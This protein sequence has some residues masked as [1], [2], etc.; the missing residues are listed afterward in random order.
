MLIVKIATWILRGLNQRFPKCRAK[1]DRFE[2]TLRRFSRLPDE[3]ST[4]RINVFDYSRYLIPI[5]LFN[6]DS[7]IY[8]F[9]DI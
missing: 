2:P 8:F 9:S 3:I 5:E 1:K 7:E 4:D 6:Y